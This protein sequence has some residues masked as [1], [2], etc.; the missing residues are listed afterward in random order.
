MTIARIPEITKALQTITSKHYMPIFTVEDIVEAESEN[1]SERGKQ[2]LH[3]H[4]AKTYAIESAIEDCDFAKL[5]KLITI[6]DHA[7]GSK[8]ANKISISTSVAINPICK[9]RRSLDPKKYVCP[10]CFANAI[11]NARPTARRS[12]KRNSFILTSIII[13]VEYW[14]ALK[15]SKKQRENAKHGIRIESLGDVCNVLQ[16]INYINLVKAFPHYNFTAW[17]K[18]WQLWEKAFAAVGKPDNLIYIHSSSRLNAIDNPK[19]AF[20]AAY[21]DYDFTVYERDFAIAHTEINYNC[22]TP[23]ESRQCVRDCNE[24]Y[25]KG[26]CKHRAEILR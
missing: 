3:G 6:T 8:M 2:Y 4:N 12:C 21:M 18:N 23:Y 13:P 10:H 1:M 9:A 20:A 22:C 17:S 14:K 5:V 15:L 25:S 16:C 26:N 11:S 7:A 19:A 24:C